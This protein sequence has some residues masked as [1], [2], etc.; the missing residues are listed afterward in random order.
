MSIIL[1]TLVAVY[2]VGI[3]LTCLL[4]GITSA[5]YNKLDS[6]AWKGDVSLKL[7]LI[8]ITWPITFMFAIFVTL[9]NAMYQNGVK[10]GKSNK[11]LVGGGNE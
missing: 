4:M 5:V 6:S 8:C 3:P 2:V 7:Y 9:M 1:L 11:A 10:I